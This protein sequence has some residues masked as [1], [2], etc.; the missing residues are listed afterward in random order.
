MRTLRAL[1]EVSVDVARAGLWYNR[2]QPGLGFEFAEA[3][4]LLMEELTAAPLARR[5]V[6][7]DFRRGFMKRFPYAIYYL[8]TSDEVVITLVFHTARNPA[9]VKRLLRK[10]EGTV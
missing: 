2:K 5:V 1:P 8:T 9:T 6:Y 4:Y 7:R 3:A 10:R